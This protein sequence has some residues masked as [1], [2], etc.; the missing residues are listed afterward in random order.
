MF[1]TRSRPYERLWV[2]IA[3][4]HYKNRL[5]VIVHGKTSTPVAKS[6]SPKFVVCYS[7]W[8]RFQVYYKVAL[9]CPEFTMHYAPLRTKQNNTKTLIFF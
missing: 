4:K 1:S 2:V 8:M 5:F 6:T 3:N 7:E 9:R